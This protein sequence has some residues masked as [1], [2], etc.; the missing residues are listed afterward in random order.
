MPHEPSENTSANSAD[1]VEVAVTPT[2]KLW[3][4]RRHFLTLGGVAAMSAV[5]AACSS[6]STSTDAAA[7]TTAGSAETTAETTGAAT[8]E[9]TGAAATAETTAAGVA[10][11]TAAAATAGGGN[12]AK[13]GGGGKDGTLK[14]G[15]TAPLTGPLAGFGE[16]NDF[17]L[18]TIKDLV[19]D[20][21]MIG[22][23]SYKVDIIVADVQSKSDVASSQALKLITDD[24]VDLII[25]MATPEMIN[26]V[27]DQ[28]EA[29][30]VPCLST[31]APWQPFFFGRKG[32]PAKGFDWTYHFFWGADQLVGVF[33]KLWDTAPD[34]KVVGLLCANDPDGAALSDPKTGFPAGITAAG[35]TVVDP[36]RFQALTDDFS[37]VISELKSKNAEVLTGVPLPPDFA[38]FWQQAQQQGYKPKVVTMAKAILFPAAVAALPNNGD[39]LASEVWW[40]PNHPFASSLTKTTAKELSDQYTVETKKQW[41]QFVGYVHALFEVALDSV[42][43][44]GSTDKKAIADAF[45]ATKLDTIV[46][47]IAFA[48]DGRPK[49]IAATPLV[50][51][52]WQKTNGGQF[53]IDLVIVENTQA[54]N[55][56]KGGDIKPLE[57]K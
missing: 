42:S 12:A 8:S 17:T 4:D 22:S 55:I 44:A 13:F 30:G 21:L 25:A 40:S 23:K 49:N 7:E 39:G 35:K 48:Q 18:K 5:L 51:G 36:G 43:R 9:T 11:T 1:A 29:N 32:D 57:Y 50:G 3:L 14:I 31:L 6:D 20:G 56:P 45:G 47:P 28:C 15:F 27:A 53:P 37:A 33:S 34:S 10:E 2:K 52:Q 38:T 46:G 41:T 19:K 16:A 24:G 54:P 26:P